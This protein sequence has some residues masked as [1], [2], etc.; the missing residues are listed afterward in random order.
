MSLLRYLQLTA[1]LLPEGLEGARC[2]WEKSGDGRAA[3]GMKLCSPR[4]PLECVTRST[5]LTGRAP[6]AR[7]WTDSNFLPL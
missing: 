7:H 4:R 1:N 3:A 6:S 5:P 2:S